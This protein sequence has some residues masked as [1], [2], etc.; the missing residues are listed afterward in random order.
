MVGEDVIEELSLMELLLLMMPVKDDGVFGPGLVGADLP[1]TKCSDIF[2][3]NTG[4]IFPD[5]DSKFCVG[6]VH[7]QP[8]AV[9]F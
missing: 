2:G 7:L 3:G 4:A 1:P 6:S 5:W 9:H 8:V